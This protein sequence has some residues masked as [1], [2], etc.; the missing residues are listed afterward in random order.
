MLC[1]VNVHL[2][3]ENENSITPLKI[4][5]LLNVISVIVQFK[6]VYSLRRKD[7]FS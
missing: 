4:A 5:P 1:Y 7:T 6:E 3:A 2:E